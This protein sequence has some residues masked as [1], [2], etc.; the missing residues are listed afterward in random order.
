MNKKTKKKNEKKERTFEPKSRNAKE[1]GP[2]NREEP[3]RTN[4]KTKKRNKKKR[5]KKNVPSNRRAEMLKNW[6]LR[7]NEIRTK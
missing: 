2:K 7:R 3:V 4:K 1:L 6:D 5:K